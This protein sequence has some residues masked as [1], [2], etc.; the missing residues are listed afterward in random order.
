[1]LQV[2]KK[3]AGFVDNRNR[4]SAAWRKLEAKRRHPE[5]LFRDEME[6]RASSSRTRRAGS[7]CTN[8]R[9]RARQSSLA[10]GRGRKDEEGKK[11]KK[12]KVT[13]DRREQFLVTFAA[14][15]LA[16]LRSHYKPSPFRRKKIQSNPNSIQFN[17][18]QFNSG[19]QVQTFVGY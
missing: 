16:T 5:R 11:A 15:N 14:Y 18:I 8:G 6:A 13:K 4:W 3:V 2:Q 12:G 10:F 7:L 9:I 1:V 17:S 19:A